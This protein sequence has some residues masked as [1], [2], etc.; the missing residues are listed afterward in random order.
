MTLTGTSLI[1]LRAGE[2][3]IIKH[4]SMLLDHVYPN[5]Q[6]RVWKEGKKWMLARKNTP[7]PGQDGLLKYGPYLTKIEAMIECAW[8]FGREMLAKERAEGY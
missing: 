1:V 7:A 4:P 6:Y 3:T 5:V 2:N 8:L